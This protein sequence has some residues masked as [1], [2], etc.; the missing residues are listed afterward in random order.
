MPKSWRELQAE[1]VKRCCVMFKS[2]KRCR[3]RAIDG[4][5][6]AKHQHHS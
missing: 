6:C 4:E 5:W 3:H 2:G 1:G